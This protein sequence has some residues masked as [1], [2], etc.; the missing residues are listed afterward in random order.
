MK[1]SSA[2][3]STYACTERLQG[4]KESRSPAMV[5]PSPRQQAGVSGSSPKH[6]AFQLPLSDSLPSRQALWSVSPFPDVLALHCTASEGLLG[7]GPVAGG[8]HGTRGADD[9]GRW[10]KQDPLSEGS[11]F[12]HCFFCSSIS[13]PFFVL[14]RRGGTF[15]IFLKIFTVWLGTVAHAYN[16]SSL[17]SGDQEEAVWG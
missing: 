10:G 8:L 12:C 4:D 5:N 1:S 11:F 15:W 3:F 14:L 9:I 2:H 16:P 7:V 13:L 17:G 6:L